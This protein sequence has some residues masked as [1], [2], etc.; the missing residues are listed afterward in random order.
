MEDLFI[1]ADWVLPVS[2]TP[3]VAGAVV[4]RGGRIAMIGPRAAVEPLAGDA[5]RID[6]DRAALLP[7]LVNV[8]AHLELTALRGFLEDHD[9]FA[10]IRRL[11]R[12]KYEL[13]DEEAIL[14][15]ARQGVVEATLAGVT[16]LGEVCDLGVSRTALEEGGL[17][18]VLFQEVFGPDPRDVEA[19]L[20]ALRAR[21]AVHDRHASTRL[22]VG[23]SPHAPYT[24]SEP[25][26]RAVVELA[27]AEGRPWTIHAAESAAEDAYLRDGRGPFAEFLRGRGIEVRARGVS[28]LAWLD[29][30]GALETRPLLVHCVRVDDDDLARA[31]AAGASIAHCPKSNAKLGHGS[32]RWRA[33]RRA[34]LAV[35]LGSDGVVSNNAMDLFEESRVAALFDRAI[36]FGSPAAGARDSGDDDRSTPS[37]RELV[38][39]VT[40]DGARAL[41]LDAE[42]GSLE[43]GKRADLCAVDLSG[44]H[45]EPIHD[46]ETAVVW[47]A[48][49]R[50]VVLTIVDGCVLF[51]RGRL[52]RWDREALAERL[53]NTAAKLGAS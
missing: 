28:T 29:G 48:G 10:W 25:L 6:L 42:V 46:V 40:L 41:G 34:G 7:G 5:R 49:A 13:L 44:A 47:S 50:D 23:V 3:L 24:V 14:D 31:S 16:T 9:F 19:S 33:M 35:G 37:A 21:L 18:A 20:A 53:R 36:S 27:R 52:A 30:L 1:T 12:A 11:T 51:E 26:L 2:S 43:R 22:Q 8:H 4:V 38:Q 17:R 32:A 39:L 45:S 15:S